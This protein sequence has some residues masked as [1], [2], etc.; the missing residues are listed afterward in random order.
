LTLPF[1]DS[2]LA[3]LR[4]YDALLL[5]L[6]YLISDSLTGFIVSAFDLA[7]AQIAINSL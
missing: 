5:P 1:K 3:S 4:P 7:N 6:A 2:N